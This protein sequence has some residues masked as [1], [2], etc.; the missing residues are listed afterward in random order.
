MTG[1]SRSHYNT[2]GRQPMARGAVLLAALLAVVLQTFVVQ[3][4]VHTYGAVREA[5]YEQGQ[6]SNDNAEVHLTNSG[7]KFGCAICD[8]LA[9][10]GHSTRPEANTVA[11][12]AVASNEVT[13][14][15]IRRAPRALTHSWQS[16]APPIAL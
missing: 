11:T 1:M 2:R 8:V 10:A 16:R 3:T 15:A 9:T 13:A 7:D 5:G 12:E 4:H 14:L 6:T